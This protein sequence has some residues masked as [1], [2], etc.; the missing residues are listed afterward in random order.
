MSSN[1]SVSVE[2]LTKQ[3]AALESDL[4]TL[5]AQ[6]QQIVG[7]IKLTQHLI[8]GAEKPVEDSAPETPAAEQS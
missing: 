5:E 7:M 4:K 8:Q 1:A 3:L 2:A 6:G